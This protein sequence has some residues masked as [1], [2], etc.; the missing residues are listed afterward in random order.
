MSTRMPIL[1]ST[2]DYCMQIDRLRNALATANAVIIGAG[3][4]L[5]A[6]A[7]MTYSG[8]RFEENFSDFIAKY[9]FSDMYTA[10][11]YPY[12]TQEE[13]WAYWSRHIKL[14]RY[15]PIPNITYELLMKL[16]KDKDY[17]VLT[18]NVDHCF[19]RAGFAKERLFYTQG[20]YGLW[21]CAKP[22]HQKT[23]DNEARVME[24]VALQK[25]M[26]IPSAL[27]PRCPVCA[28][29]MSMN[30]RSDMSFVEDALWHE[31]NDRYEAFVQKHH[32][33]RVVYLELGV[34]YNTPGIIKLPFWQMTY[35]NKQAIF[36]TINAEQ[37]YAP[38]EI[39][40]RSI[41]IGEDITK[42]I[43]ELIVSK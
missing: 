31:A 27:I 11:F 7:G 1:T 2:K 18:T 21:Q 41:C 39:R 42:I 16:V 30:L 33:G 26:R 14:N 17:F 19:Q 25:D 3:A 5:S 32:K 6:S 28:E 23:Y 20:D 40:D 34:G 29:P 4:G 13:H 8:K 35:Q 15:D 24:M 9:H 10:G 38:D 43:S 22:C 36:S 37:P 12:A